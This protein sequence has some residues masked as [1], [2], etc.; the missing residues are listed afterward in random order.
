MTKLAP[1]IL[2]ADFARLGEEIRDVEQG[3]ADWIHVDVMDGHFVPNL[4]IGPLVVE[5]IRPHTSLPLDVH[6]MIEHPERYINDF[7]R[8]GADWITV[9]QEVCPH[10]HRTLA[11]IRESGAKAGV[12]LNPGTS[13]SAI[14]PVLQEVDLILLMT[15]NPGFGGQVFIP[16]VTRKI[17][18]TTRL[19]RERGFTR[20]EIEVDGGIQPGTA[21]E[22]AAAGATVF[23]AGS[24]VFGQADRKQALD[25]IRADAEAGTVKRG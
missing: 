3:G 5:A 15:V 24:A 25:A 14:E 6:L 20:V 7:V 18:E 9:H 13:V 2:S 23:V 17:R 22:A 21:R 8:A 4:T 10:L 12:A 11:Q 19:L 16:S 1:S